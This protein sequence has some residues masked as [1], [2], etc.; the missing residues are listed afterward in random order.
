MAKNQFTKMIRTDMA[1]GF[2]KI[3]IERLAGEEHPFDMKLRR[4]ARGTWQVDV[5]TT[6]TDYEYFSDLLSNPEKWT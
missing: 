5:C 3:L 1:A 2:L 6:A 4:I